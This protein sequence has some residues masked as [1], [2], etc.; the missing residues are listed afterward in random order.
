MHFILAYKETELVLEVHHGGYNQ[1]VDLET[2]SIRRKYDLPRCML[3]IDRYSLV[4]RM[5]NIS[6]ADNEILIESSFHFLL[7]AEELLRNPTLA[8][9][10]ELKALEKYSQHDGNTHLAVLASPNIREKILST[11]SG[12]LVSDLTNSNKYN[13]HYFTLNNRKFKFVFVDPI[14]RAVTLDEAKRFD[15]VICFVPEFF[16][17]RQSDLSSRI[18]QYGSACQIHDDKDFNALQYL[19][20]EFCP[21]LATSARTDRKSFFSLL[22][23][24]LTNA[25]DLTCS[26]SYEQQRVALHHLYE[27]LFCMRVGPFN[28]VPKIIYELQKLLSAN[29]V[30]HTRTVNEAIYREIVNQLTQSPYTDDPLIREIE[31]L[32]AIPAKQPPQHNSICSIS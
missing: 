22:P 1:R 30:T 4:P 16:W 6:V 3:A 2:I 20:D 8:K 7:Y 32:F 18:K 31:L 26:Q 14:T 25:V 19:K 12:A 10:Q 9:F 17:W 21:P 28:R 5:S 24:D 15:R 13:V 29:Y 27:K 11:L 23:S